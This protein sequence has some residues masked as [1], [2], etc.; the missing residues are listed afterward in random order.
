MKVQ[1]GGRHWKS[2]EHVER[3]AELERAIAPQRK[4]GFRKMLDQISADLNSPLTVLDLGAGDGIVTRFI[5]EHFPNSV[6]TLVDFS[7]PMIEKGRTRLEAY[8]GRFR[9]ETW[10][11]NV[12]NWPE[13]LRGPFDAVVS[14]AALHHLDN[15]RKD[16][17]VREVASRLVPGGVFANYD[18]FSNPNA[19]FAEDDT[20]GKTCATIA[21]WVQFLLHADYADISIT[22]RYPRPQHQGE[23]VLVTGRQPKAGS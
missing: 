2:E 11:M 13:I 3:W 10:D 22:A 23:L 12:G 8:T 19:Q 4:I 7:V 5:L 9:Y 1:G 17:L 6:A 18:L 15:S 16:W 14:S 20:H 21:E